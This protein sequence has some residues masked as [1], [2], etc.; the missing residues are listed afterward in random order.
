MSW[1]G[2]ICYVSEMDTSDGLL[3]SH[4]V[5][6]E[7][8]THPE[9]IHQ[10]VS[11][12]PETRPGWEGDTWSGSWHEGPSLYKYGDYWYHFVS[13]GHLG[14][15]YTIRMGRGGAPTGPFYDK[16]GIDMMAFDEER[17]AFGQSML[18]G[19]EGRQLVP[20]HPHIWEEDGSFFMGFDFRDRKSG[21]EM[22]FMGIRRLYWV[23]GW[24]TIWM[25]LEVILVTDEHPEAIGKKLGVRFRNS[26]ETG[27]E[28]GVDLVSLGVTE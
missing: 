18:L 24:P 20:G 12:W 1:G 4:P 9:G 27:S 10:A 7:F 19:D 3:I 28:L 13:Y 23:D 6:T 11:T 17:N 26:G 15:N 14:Y 8:N 2:G 5:N 22:D 16:E 21:P 25:P